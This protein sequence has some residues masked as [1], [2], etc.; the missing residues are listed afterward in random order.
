MADRYADILNFILETLQP[1]GREVGISIG[2]STRLAD[3]LGLD[4]L[5]TMELVM[6]VEDHY[7]LSIP[8]NLLGEVSTCGELARGVEGLLQAG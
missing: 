5:R 2:E 8:I 3:E 1:V 6:E 4:S 7:D